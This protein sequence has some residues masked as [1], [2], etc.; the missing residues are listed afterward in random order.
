MTNEQIQLAIDSLKHEPPR[1]EL[2]WRDHD[3]Q[4]IQTVYRESVVICLWCA[5]SKLLQAACGE[6]FVVL[7]PCETSRLAIPQTAF[8]AVADAMGRAPMRLQE[9]R[10]ALLDA[11][12]AQ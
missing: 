5:N 6:S 12:K 10:K 1:P 4:V 9:A 3:W 7:E 11:K 8:H 2:L